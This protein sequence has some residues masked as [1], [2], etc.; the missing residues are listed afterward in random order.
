MLRTEA[1]WGE[2]EI[3]RYLKLVAKV[4]DIVIPSIALEVV[5][6]DPDDDRILECA[7]AGHADLIASGDRHLTR[8]R[9]FEGIGIV[10][11]VDFQRTLGM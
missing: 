9:S 6:D 3:I 7:T 1:K 5:V 4:A 10:R 2:P 8:L 11:P